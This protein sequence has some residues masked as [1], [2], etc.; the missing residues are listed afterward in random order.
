MI[1]LCDKKCAYQV[2][3]ENSN[4]KSFWG[5]V[6]PLL[7]L[8]HLLVTHYA[9]VQSSETNMHTLQCSLLPLSDHVIQSAA[10]AETNINSQAGQPF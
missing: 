2:A 5:K 1:K 7:L 9:I 6:F 8:L 3:A 4:F 10:Y